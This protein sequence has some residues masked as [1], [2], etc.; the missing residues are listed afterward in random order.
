MIAVRQSWRVAVV[1]NKQDVGVI[2]CTCPAVVVQNTA[3]RVIGH[4]LQVKLLATQ[5]I[6]R[7]M[8]KEIDTWEINHLQ[9]RKAMLLKIFDHGGCS[10]FV[11]SRNNLVG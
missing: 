11:N 9:V 5:W 3:D 2:Q 4:R 10:V 8:S 1:G 7:M 6:G